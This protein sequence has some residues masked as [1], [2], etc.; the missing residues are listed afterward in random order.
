L[1]IERITDMKKFYVTTSLI[2]AFAVIFSLTGCVNNSADN[3]YTDGINSSEAA[4]TEQ[5]NVSGNMTEPEKVQEEI[6]QS[7][8]YGSIS[9]VLPNGWSYVLCSDSESLINGKYGIRFYPDDVSEGYV[10]IAY[11]DIVGL[12]GTGLSEEEVTLAGDKA[13]ICTYDNK[14]Y[15]DLV[16]YG[17]NN[18]GITAFTYD[19]GD[20]WEQYGNQVLD[21]LDTLSFETN[22]I[23][24]EN[25]K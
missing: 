13:F 15:W 21:I 1:N 18:K 2:L 10:E 19:T 7:G 11:T 23:Y 22:K 3:A 6:T 9:I 4:A 12:C 16:I 14:T 25:I 20:W 17:G 24:K 5:D 8:A